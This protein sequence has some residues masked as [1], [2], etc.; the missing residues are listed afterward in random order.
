M[1]TIT[2]LTYREFGPALFYFHNFLP[3]LWQ[4]SLL[5][6]VL[7]TFT[8]RLGHPTTTILQYKTNTSLS[9]LRLPRH[10]QE[11]LP[12]RRH[13]PQPTLPRHRMRRPGLR[14][15]PLDAEE[16]HAM[17]RR[18]FHATRNVSCSS[19]RLHIRQIAVDD[20]VGWTW[21]F[22]VDCGL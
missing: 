18:P 10:P 15:F 19:P 1:N 20:C 5:R 3:R 16:L 8:T 6:H 11:Q 2:N 22:H 7:V 17:V 13:P 21:D 9:I 12:S 14:N 4:K